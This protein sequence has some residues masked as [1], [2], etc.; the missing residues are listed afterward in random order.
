MGA[1]A[2]VFQGRDHVAGGELV[3]APVDRQPPVGEIEP[4]IDDAGD[5]L[6][7]AFDLADAGR[8]ADALD[9]EVHVRGAVVTLHEDR[10]IERLAPRHSSSLQDRRDCASGTAA[11]RRATD[12]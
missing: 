6:Q 7:P 12:R 1:I 4:R 5:L 2:D 10:K 8:A 9:R 3:L 11:R